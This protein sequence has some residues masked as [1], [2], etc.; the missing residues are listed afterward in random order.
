VAVIGLDESDLGDAARRAAA[1]QDIPGEA[2]IE[3]HP[4]SAFIGT[5][6][7]ANFVF[8]GIPAVALKVGFPGE[9]AALLQ[10]YRQS[11]YHTPFDDLRQPVNLET[12][13]KF[14]EVKQALLPDVA[15]NPSRPQW[16][17]SSFYKRYAVSRRH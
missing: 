12:F 15:N 11:P 2:E 3:L 5:S 16:K 9:S 13:A 8:A 4:A 10:A 14:E 17:S 1:T 7:Q 6:D